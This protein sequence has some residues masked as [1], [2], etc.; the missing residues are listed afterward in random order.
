M[1]KQVH[2]QT[3]S[4]TA[5]TREGRIV[6]NWVYGGFL[7]GILLLGLAPVLTLG[8]DAT[9]RLVYLSLPIYMLHQYEEHDADRFRKFMNLTMAS[10][11]DAMT[12]LAV[13]VINIFGV[14]LS[15]AACIA[16]VRLDQVGYGAFAGWFLAVNSALHVVT[17][18]R[19]RSYNP[20]LVTA[21]V[22]FLPLASVILTEVWKQASPGQLIGGLALSVAIHVSIMIHMR[23]Q[24]A[25]LRAGAMSLPL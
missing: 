6:N 2:E 4:A 20:G 14:W 16:L 1:N 9:Q 5:G 10:G 18:V 25:K 12:P 8:W 7:A 3:V 19:T 23:V 22:L 17:A 13:F 11:H 21:I 15:L 24:I